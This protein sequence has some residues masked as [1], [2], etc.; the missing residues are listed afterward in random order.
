MALYKFCIVIIIIIIIRQLSDQLH[1][2]HWTYFG[3]TVKNFHNINCR[4]LAVVLQKGRAG[5]SVQ[6]KLH[7]H[8]NFY[9]WLSMKCFS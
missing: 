4:I 2:Q 9:I 6:S 1:T 7:W 8:L 5:M 3:Y